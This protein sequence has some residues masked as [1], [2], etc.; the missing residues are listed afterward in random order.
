MLPSNKLGVPVPTHV[1]YVVRQT[2]DFSAEERAKMQK[3]TEYNVFFFPAQMLLCDYLSDSG[4][5]AMT[6]IQ[7][8]SLFRGDES[9]GRN[10]GYYAFQESIRD[11][12]ERGDKAKWV[13]RDIISGAPNFTNNPN[14]SF[15][16]EEVQEGTFCNKGI[17]QMERPNFFIVP[18]GRCA[19][20]LL[21]EVMSSTL[22]KGEWHLI[23][24]GW[25]DTTEANARNNGFKTINM[26]AK[27]YNDPVDVESLW[28]TNTF[29]GDLDIERAEAYINEKGPENV[30]MILL[31]ITNNTGAG[32][33]VSMKNIRE[34]SELAKKFDIPMWFDAARFAENAYFIHEFEEGYQNVSINEIVKEMF[35]Y[36][37][38]FCI[39]L[40]KDGL[41]NMGGALSF[42]DKGVFWRK[43]SKNGDVGV[44]L[45]QNQILHY[46]NDSYGG[47]S[48]RDIL[49]CA[50][51][52]NIILKESYLRERIHQV[53]YFAHELAK[54]NIPVFL[55]PGGHAIYIKCDEFFSNRKDYSPGD[56]LGVGLT[57]E[58][59]RMYGIRACEL[60]P[61]GFEWDN[62]D[63][64]DRKGINDQVRFAVPRN[65]YSKEHIDYTVAA[66]E[67]MFINRDKIPKVR[68]S[69]GRHLKLRHFQS[70]LEPVYE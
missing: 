66:I 39:S 6:D 38:G 8:S 60:G 1:S 31:T 52:L 28:K 68:I 11:A 54:K 50:M 3:N 46:G 47:L 18:Q 58:L 56:F 43:F 59:I 16:T 48:G 17:L 15:W 10:H 12:F 13:I 35:S 24:N 4:S 2:N 27:H 65:V 19:E 70:G 53:R 37:D 34:T 41:C 32:Q 33:P 51:G 49:A 29:K 22:G 9:Y 42:R 23:S 36:A 40:K 69:R 20:S 21:Y 57:L 7:W 61:F 25:F 64:E 5:S 45:K 44:I 62:K 63:E 55:P 30:P 26:F 67:Q 14:D